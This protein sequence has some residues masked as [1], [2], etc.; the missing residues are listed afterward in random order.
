MLIKKINVSQEQ[1]ISTGNFE[2]KRIQYGI[3]A[4]LSET[5]NYT[6]VYNHLRGIIEEELE[7]EYNNV[8]E[9][10]SET[11]SI[12]PE[13]SLPLKQFDPTDTR[14][15]I[16]CPKCGSPM[17]LKKGRTGEFWGCSA[18]KSNNCNGIVNLNQVETYLKTGTLTK[19]W[20]Y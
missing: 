5:D 16:K 6:A 14:L 8:K 11:K 10:V 9:T 4:E 1:C 15:E 20:G 12:V 2:S 19:K 3:E 18:F 13:L 17:T 7:K